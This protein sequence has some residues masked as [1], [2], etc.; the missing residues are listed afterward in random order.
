MM[1]III[2]GKRRQFVLRIHE[3]QYDHYVSD[4]IYY[5]INNQ[6]VHYEKSLGDH[7]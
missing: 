2:V 7:S 5:C 6:Y 1:K 3:Y 4:V